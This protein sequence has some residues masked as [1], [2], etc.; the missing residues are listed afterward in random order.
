M[1]RFFE[2]GLLLVGGDFILGYFHE[3]NIPN[4][5]RPLSLLNCVSSSLRAVGVITRVD[6]ECGLLLL[7]AWGK[8]KEE[9]E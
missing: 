6:D 3:Q 2:K 1:A 9:R 7:P 8:N 4:V 5:S